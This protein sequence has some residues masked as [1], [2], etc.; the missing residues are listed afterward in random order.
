VTLS[1]CHNGVQTETYVKEKNTSYMAVGIRNDLK[2][3]KLL[4]IYEMLWNHLFERQY[5]MDHF[6]DE[7]STFLDSVYGK[8]CIRR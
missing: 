1:L 3:N 7:A 4:H 8:T 2:N 5:A 6:L